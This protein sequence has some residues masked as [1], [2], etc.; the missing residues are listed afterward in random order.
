M[1]TAIWVIAVSLIEISNN[2]KETPLEE[3]SPELLFFMIAVLMV[4]V[5]QDLKEMFRD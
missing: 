2:L 5:L 3:T 4:V 1:R